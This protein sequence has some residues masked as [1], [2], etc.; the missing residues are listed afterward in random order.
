MSIPTTDVDALLAKLNNNPDLSD[1]EKAYLREQLTAKKKY[2]LI[3]EE[4]PEAVEQQLLTGLP[5][6]TELPERRVMN[7]ATNEAK[8]DESS[9]LSVS[10]HTVKRVD[11]TTPA[12]PGGQTTLVFNSAKP[13]SLGDYYQSPNEA[14]LA[15][16]IIDLTPSPSPKTGEG[17]NTI[18]HHTLIEGDNLHALTIL[19]YTHAGQVDVIYIDPPYNTGNKDFKYNDTFKD[20]YIDKENPFRHSTWLSFMNRRLR[21]AKTLL[22]DTGVIF[23]SID[24]NEQAQLKL[25][26][27]E[28]FGE[29]NCISNMT[30]KKSY[31]GGAKAKHIV[32]LTEYVLCYANNIANIPQLDLPPDPESKKYY[33]GVDEKFDT[34]GPFRTQPLATNSMDARP[35]LRYPI[36]YQGEEVWPEKQWQWS[37]GRVEEALANKELLISKIKGKWSVRYKQYLIS[38]DGSERPAKLFSLIEGMFTQDGTNAIKEMFDDG[39]AFS[40]PKP[41]ALIKLLLSIT[42]RNKNALVLDFFA[43]SGTT[44]HAVMALNAEDGGNRRCILVTNNENNIAEEV[45]YE[46]NRRVIEGYTNSKGMAVPGLAGN[47]LHYYRTGLVPLNDPAELVRRSVV[48][49][50]TALL[51]LKEACYQSITPEGETGFA[52]FGNEQHYLCIIY[53]DRFISRA[54]DHIATLEPL[55]GGPAHRYVHTYVYSTGTQTYDAEFLPVRDRVTLCALPEAILRAYQETVLQLKTAH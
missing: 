29:E 54:V 5:V 19:N 10:T 40:F 37:K 22:K 42:W 3:W 31:G 53:N 43:G 2:G 33:T 34:R 27:D 35:N 7:P 1:L 45:C 8:P 49:Q 11:S 50:A 39:K 44:L 46:R 20:E 17:G 30:W 47:A 36:L 4:K 41:P 32:G 23:I 48:Q 12:T 26:C 13:A 18:T 38:D 55:P 9:N 28:V 25:L 6:L 16:S 14:G 24:D 51:C 15:E 52:L 21:L